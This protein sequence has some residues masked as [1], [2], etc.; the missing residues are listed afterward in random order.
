MKLSDQ[1]IEHGPYAAGDSSPLP[2][3]LE[4]RADVHDL[5]EL[6]EELVAARKVGGERER[7]EVRATA[8]C[9]DA[10]LWVT[11]GRCG[12]RY[13]TWVFDEPQTLAEL[14]RRASEH[15]EVCR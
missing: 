10:Q 11:C 15:A 14:N 13:A 12:G 7:F 6:R 5:N 2:G 3:E 8:I 4:H 9:E 1:I